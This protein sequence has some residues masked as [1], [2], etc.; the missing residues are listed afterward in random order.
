MQSTC[1]VGEIH[2]FELNATRIE[3]TWRARIGARCGAAFCIIGEREALKRERVQ[4]GRVRP[5]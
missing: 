2:A 1:K 3:I 4:A 5:H